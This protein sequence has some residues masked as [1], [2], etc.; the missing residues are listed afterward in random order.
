MMSA[1]ATTRSSIFQDGAQEE[2]QDV[3]GKRIESVYAGAKRRIR[4]NQDN[5]PTHEL[6]ITQPY[7]R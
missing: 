7:A 6:P 1:A 3:A 2:D 5:V 4:M